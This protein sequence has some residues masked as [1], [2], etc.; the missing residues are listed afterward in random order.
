MTKDEHVA[1]MITDVI[2]RGHY[3]YVKRLEGDENVA[4][5]DIRVDQLRHSLNSTFPTDKSEVVVREGATAFVVNVD[6]EPEV[7]ESLLK[8]VTERRFK[9][10]EIIRLTDAEFRV[11]RKMPPCPPRNP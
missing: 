6:S 3:R 2:A 9:H 1:H 10:G 11:Y 7:V 5:V 4:C 8:K